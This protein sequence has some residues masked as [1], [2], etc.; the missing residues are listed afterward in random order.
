MRPWLCEEIMC[1]K[2]KHDNLEQPAA[3][4]P[5]LNKTAW[6]EYE[7]KTTHIMWSLH[8]ATNIYIIQHNDRFR[9]NSTIKAQLLS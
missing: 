2:R 5:R 4:N 6:D 7:E 9:K 3:D 1:R 8:S